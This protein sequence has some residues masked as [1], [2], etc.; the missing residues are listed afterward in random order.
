V[1]Y[2]PAAFAEPA[3]S[4]GGRSCSFQFII[5]R[6]VTVTR[7]HGH[8]YFL[9]MITRQSGPMIP[10]IET[11]HNATNTNVKSCQKLSLLI[12]LSTDGLSR[13][14]GPWAKKYNKLI[15]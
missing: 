1:R 6:A 8:G 7:V 11:V 13:S 14:S 9:R 4:Q 10:Y 5:I 3:E 15:F 12:V 2:D